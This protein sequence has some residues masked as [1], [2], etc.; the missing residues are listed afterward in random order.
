MSLTKQTQHNKLITYSQR[1][2]YENKYKDLLLKIN[3][4]TD[5]EEWAQKNLGGWY[6]GYLLEYNDDEYSEYLGKACGVFLPLVSTTSQS[7]TSK[8][9]S[10]F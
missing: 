4:L 9:V 2:Q 1:R 8:K 10:I 5:F 3:K 7:I 6:N